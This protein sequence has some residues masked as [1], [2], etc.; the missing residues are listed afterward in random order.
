MHT[1]RTAVAAAMLSIGLLAAGGGGQPALAA[2]AP[3]PS[4][5]GDGYLLDWENPADW[6]LPQRPPPGWAYEYQPSIRH[7]DGEPQVRLASAANGEPVRD[8][9]HSVRFDLDKSDP[10]LHN[11]SRAQLGAEDPVEPRGAERWYGFSIYLPSTWTRDRAPEVVAQWHQVGGDCS[12]GCS[13]PLSLIT[14]DGQ[15]LISQNWEIS[16]GNWHFADTPIG[17]YETGRWID[18]VFHVKWSTGDDGRLDV[19]KDGHAVP[20]F[21]Q[22]QGRTDDY[23]NGTDGNYLVLGIYKWPWSQGKPSDTTRRVMYV[24]ALRVADERGSLA[25]VAPRDGPISAGHLSLEGD[26]TLSGR[27][28]EQPTTAAFT[29]TNDGGSAMSVPYFLTGSRGPGNT[30][31]DFPASAPVTLQPGQRYTYQQSRTLAAGTYTAW[32]AYYDGTQW[33][34]LGPRSTF[35]VTGPTPPGGHPSDD[36]VAG[37][38]APADL[39]FATALRSTCDR[40]VAP[41]GTDQPA[42]GSADSPLAHVSYA[43]A[44]LTAGQ[45]LCVQ[46]GTYSEA[47]ADTAASGSPSA[48]IVVRAAPGATSRPVLHLARRHSA[49]WISH[50]YWVVQGLELDLAAQVV[51]GVVVDAPAHHVVLRD[52]VVRHTRGGAAVFVRGDDVAI[53]HNEIADNFKYTASGSLDDSHGVLVTDGAARVRISDNR[54]H[55]NSGDGVQCEYNGSAADAAAPVDLAIEDNRFW[56]DPSN[57]GKVEQAVDIKACR[58]VSIRGT[59]SPDLDDADAAGQKMFGFTNTAGGRGGG[60][61][62]LHI[63]SRGVLVENNRIWNS[64]FG[65]TAGDYDP[66]QWPDT[67]SVVIR[68]NVVFDL[69]T[70]NGSCSGHAL[71]FQRVQHVDIAHNTIDDV[72]GDAIS[73]GTSNGRPDVPMG[74]VDFWNNVVRDARSFVHLSTGGVSGFASDHNLFFRRDGSTTRFILNGAARSLAQ[75]HS[76]AS[77]SSILLA[78]PHS[79]VVDPLFVPGAGTSEDYYTQPGSPARDVALDNTGSHRGAAGPDIGFRESYR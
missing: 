20:G 19:W 30:N 49:L 37:A 65:V 9:S 66:A 61:I 64:C 34:E 22:K 1:R 28:T 55:D 27:R 42:G 71:F 58:Q 29:V 57:Y 76:A 54:I 75:W 38:R 6:T 52:S 10:P 13:P 15:F 4:L 56:T 78:D 70:S 67:Q 46:P 69:T 48:P 79:R 26:L 77:G 50:S 44:R 47:G 2:Q 24:D 62:V 53:Q 33:H 17:A 39:G 25:A 31:R 73:L 36:V 32:P 43:V 51:S 63:G 35:T 74:D 16:P 23:G 11:G 18:W 21:S 3:S 68:R 5:P 12:N 8:G 59:R 41:G 14:R 40:Y 7:A 72:P 60:A 45:V